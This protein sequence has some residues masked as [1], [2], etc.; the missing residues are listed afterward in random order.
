MICN[1]A[2]SEQSSLNSDDPLLLFVNVHRADRQQPL[3]AVNSI[4]QPNQCFINFHHVK[5]SNL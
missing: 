1:F 4:V 2:Q 5:L 3:L